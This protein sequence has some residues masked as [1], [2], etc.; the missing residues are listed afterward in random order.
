MPIYGPPARWVQVA[1]RSRPARQTARRP[2]PGCCWTTTSPSTTSPVR[3]STTAGSSRCLKPEGLQGG[4]RAV[5]WDPGR[6]TVTL[7]ALAIIRDG[8]RIDLLK[9]GEDVLV[10]RR[11]KNL[12]RA[13]LDG[14]M[15]ASIQIKD[16]QVGDVVDWAYTLEHRDPLVGGRTDDFERMGWTGVAGRCRVRLLWTDG[17]PLTWKASTAFPAPKVSK[18]GKTNELLVDV[19]G[20]AAPKPPVGAPARFQRLGMLEATTYSGWDDI[21]RRM[22]PLYIKASELSAGL[23]PARRDRGDRRRQPRPQGP[24][25]QG[26]AAGRGQDALPVPGHER[27]RLQARRGRRTWSRRFG[28]CKGKT[29]LLL[30]I[31]REL[32]RRGRAGAGPDGGRRRPWRSARPRRPCSTTC[33]SAL[34][35]TARATGWTA[36]DRATWATSTACA[37]RRSAGACRC[38]RPARRSRRSS[39]R[40]STSPRPRRW[41]GSTPRAAS[42]SRRQRS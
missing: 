10:L 34:A 42:T 9:K 29:V 1:E 19:S 14:R 17:A 16:L 40:R 12:E 36:H 24:R 21:S 38:A 3:P 32:R 5:T 35:S 11:E 27:R 7:H 26:A 28:D 22:A 39:S 41:S 30:A 6:E 18:S 20:A 13:M 31:L 37:R 25:L 23:V 15:T 2:R 8:Q 4:S 33:W